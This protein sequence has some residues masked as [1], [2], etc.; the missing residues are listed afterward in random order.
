MGLGRWMGGFRG[1]GWVYLG[2]GD[3]WFRAVEGWV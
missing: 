2:A 3:G 1:W